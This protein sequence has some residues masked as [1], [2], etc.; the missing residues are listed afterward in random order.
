MSMPCFN[1]DSEFVKDAV[2][3]VLGTISIGPEVH[4]G[5]TNIMEDEQ[6]LLATIPIDCITK[7]SETVEHFDRPTRE[8]QHH[9]VRSNLNN[10][11]AIKSY[12]AEETVATTT[13]FPVDHLNYS[14]QP[15]AGATQR[16]MQRSPTRSPPQSPSYRPNSP[17][18]QVSFPVY[19]P[20]SP[21][22]QPNSPTY[23][24]VYPPHWSPLQPPQPVQPAVLGLAIIPQRGT[25]LS[26]EYN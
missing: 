14:S 7:L 24:P 19:Q 21:T 6:Q 25:P 13:P 8:Q 16:L 12:V 18:Y 10:T 11:F 3:P 23:D 26:P 5:L 1:N 15:E 20:T 22:Y 9:H 4:Q 17:I 2:K